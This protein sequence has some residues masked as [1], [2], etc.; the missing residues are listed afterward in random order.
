MQTPEILIIGGGIIGCSLARELARVCK[1]IVVIERGRIGC[2]ASSAAAGLLAP[3]V[4]N[5]EAGALMDLCLDSVALYEEWV[6]E[7]RADG[8]GDVGFCRPG[9]LDV[10]TDPQ[11]AE[12]KQSEL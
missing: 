9:L 3:T 5:S 4:S 12:E 10:W 11:E 2:G 1:Q 8:A 7:L 6:H